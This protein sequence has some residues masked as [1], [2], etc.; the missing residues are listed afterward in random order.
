MKNTWWFR[1]FVSNSWVKTTDF[2]IFL[3]KLTCSTNYLYPK[4]GTWYSDIV[5][6]LCNHKHCQLMGDVLLVVSQSKKVRWNRL[7]S[8]WFFPAA[9]FHDSDYAQA[10]DSGCILN[11]NS[12]YNQWN[13]HLVK[14]DWTSKVFSATNWYM[15][16]CN[17]TSDLLVGGILFGTSGLWC[18]G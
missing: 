8:H 13:R 4:R 6:N 17:S 10:S 18:L 12:Q 9:A 14:P 2:Q 11:H 7:F 5:F 1:F 3:I 16:K 15:A